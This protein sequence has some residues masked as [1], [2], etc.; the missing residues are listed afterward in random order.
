MTTA[1][2]TAPDRPALDPEALSSTQAAQ[3][4]GISR[5][6]WLKM[7]TTGRIPRPVHLGRCVRWLRSELLAWLHAG[8]PPRER[9]E[10]IRRE[11]GPR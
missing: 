4:C 3:L 1:P 8:A 9:W 2:T 5:S 6:T 7:Q 11:G 10:A